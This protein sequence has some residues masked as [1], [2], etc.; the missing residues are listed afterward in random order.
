MPLLDDLHR[1]ARLLTRDRVQAEDLVQDTYARALRHFDRF[2]GGNLRAWMATIMRN[3]HR[4]RLGKHQGSAELLDALPDPSPN[5]EMAWA[6]RE[7]SARLRA[8]L[9]GLPVAMREILLLREF[10]RL[11]YAEIASALAIPQGTVMSR[12]ARAREELRRQWLALHGE[13]N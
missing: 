8:L 11:S 4:D 13:L 2:E 7:R 12:L 10:G 6:E 9:A 3:L 5:P 1:L